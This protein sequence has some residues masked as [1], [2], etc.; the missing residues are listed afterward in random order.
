MGSMVSMDFSGDSALFQANLALLK[1]RFPHIH[2][3]VE[4]HRPVFDGEVLKS[5]NGLANLRYQLSNGAAFLAYDN[6]DPWS[7]AAVHFQTVKE[8]ASGVVIFVGMGLGYGPLLILRERPAIAKL[9]IVEPSLDIFCIALRHVDLTPLLGSA[10]TFLYVGDWDPVRMERELGR[11]V[12]ISDT[13]ILK[14]QPS[15]SWQTRLYEETNDRVFQLLNKINA[16]GST[17]NYYGETFVKNRLANL[18]NIR[19]ATNT[20]ILK[21][22]LKGRPALL[23]AAGPSLDMSIPDIQK[24]VGRCAIFAVDSAL[25]TLLKNGIVPDFIA[26]LDM[27]DANFEKVAPFLASP[28]SF[29]LAITI[30]VCPLIPKRLPAQH[31]FYAFNEDIPHMWMI[32]QLGVRHLL[33]PLLSVAHLSVGLAHLMEASPIVL[34]GQDLA[35]TK[36]TGSD[37]ASGVIFH[38]K[39]LPKDKEIYYVKSITGED[40]HTDRGLMS[41]KQQFEEIVAQ[42][43][44]PIIN[45]TARG[46]HIA[47]T[48]VM[49]LAEV[50]QEFMTEEFDF[51]ALLEET[52][53][54]HKPWQN[55]QISS[56]C[57][58]SLSLCREVLEQVKKAKRLLSGGLKRIDD[59]LEKGVIVRSLEDLPAPIRN[60]MIQLDRLNNK[61][62]GYN[63]LWNQVL[64][65]TYNMLQ[66]NDKIK[67]Q[68]ERIREEQGYLAW[69]KAEL[70]RLL[71]VQEKRLEVLGLYQGLM[72]DLEH[73]LNEE[74]RL[75]KAISKAKSPED[76]LASRLELAKLYVQSEDLVLA[77]GVLKEILQSAPQE[78]TANALMGFV[79]A[80]LLN[81]EEAEVHWNRAVQLNASL[82]EEVA[83][84][85]ELAAAPWL[86]LTSHREYVAQPDG[87][88]LLWGE[89]YPHLLAQWIQ[90]IC[91]LKAAKAVS[92]LKTEVWPQYEGRL[93]A[94]VEDNAEKASSI[95][96]AWTPLLPLN[97]HASLSAQVFYRLEDLNALA[98]VLPQAMAEAQGN[99]R[100]LAFLARVFMENNRM[101][102]GIQLLTEAV[103]LEPETAVLWQELG[104]ALVESQDYEGAIAA[105]ERC[106]LSLPQRIELFKKMGDCYL[107]TGQIEA[108]KAAYEAFKERFQKDAGLEQAERCFQEGLQLQKAE[109]LEEAIARYQEAVRL[110]PGH[111][112]AWMNMGVAYSRL[113]RHMEAE[114]ALKNAL[115]C[116]EG[117]VDVL[118]NLACLYLDTKHIDE[119]E[120]LFRRV[121]ESDSSYS[122]A[123]NNLGH[124]LKEYRKAYEAA[125]TYFQKTLELSDGQGFDAARAYYNMANCHQELMDIP[126][127]IE[128]YK[129]AIALAP[130]LVEAHWNLSHVLLL[131]NQVKEGFQEYLW[132]W[133]RKEAPPYAPVSLPLWR[134]ETGPGNILVWVEQGAGDNIQFVRYLPLLREQGKRVTL[135]CGPELARLFEP[136][137]AVEQVI[138]KSHMALACENMD[139]HVP[140]LDL[141][142]H[143][144]EDSRPFPL[145]DGYLKVDIGLKGRMERLFSHMGKA[146]R[147][148]FVWKGNPKHNRDKER[149]VAFEMFKPLF[150]LPDTQ[151]FS[152]QYQSEPLAVER[153]NVHNLA[154]Y[155]VDFAH[156]A[157]ILSCLDLVITVDT[158]IAHLAGAILPPDGQ[159]RPEVWTLLAYVPDWRW[160]INTRQTP[161]YSNMQLFRQSSRNDWQEVFEAVKEAI[162]AHEKA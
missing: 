138:L 161:W 72:K 20:D 6:D 56:Y 108:A 24:A 65:L 21:G 79:L 74:D 135:A 153:A 50:I 157:A 77:Q 131:N 142:S 148:G 51:H 37:H 15:F 12:A 96:Q 162:L 61:T 69:L 120:A 11:E 124:L 126:A 130:D 59:L 114:E 71:M 43:P 106:L 22:L 47:G 128:Y 103:G 81:F 62:D 136:M 40:I 121:I 133:R 16:M 100:R 99:G 23:V 144:Q 7:S 4:Q 33:P 155:L 78:A 66:E 44:V 101:E 125:L 150:E 84:L 76:A 118:Y 134:G 122:G 159:K 52:I 48:R 102:E 91:T 86:R 110:H 58:R 105:Y 32:Q 89:R 143:L 113:N 17:T 154:P 54:S 104:D 29:A 152:L 38:E 92:A 13:H 88:Y 45:A 2:A 117:N 25:P 42:S 160:G 132:R 60:E 10:K 67:Y 87:E 35:Y 109:R 5:A 95:L 49:P 139:W 9:A 85:R 97:G 115:R 27:E 68:N 119:A 83:H 107:E 93:N 145:A 73:R 46:A 111:I 14:H 129:K 141:P 158:S 75:L 31:I 80:G 18:T 41:L 64:E 34:V 137:E 127:A 53:A 112:T 70:K 116:D 57:K 156:T 123:Y 147:I 90:R 8:D 30:K 55:S 39:G 3:L 19:H 149:S 151:W 26:S 28:L 140:L 98:D 63:E 146:L 82:N 36:T 1:Q 94:L